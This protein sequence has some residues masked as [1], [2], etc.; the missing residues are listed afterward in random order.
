MKRI[1]ISATAAATLLGACTFSKSKS[2]DSDLRFE[3]VWAK[4][5]WI[6]Q[7]A[8]ATLGADAVLDQSTM[9]DLLQKEPEEIVDGFVSDPRFGNAVLNFN[10]YFLGRS[11][12]DLFESTNASSSGYSNAVKSMP[13]AILSARNVMENKDYFDLFATEGNFVSIKNLPEGDLPS[14]VMNFFAEIDEKYNAAKAL[15]PESNAEDAC[16]N[17]MYLDNAYQMSKYI[18]PAVGKI[19]QGWFASYF[20]YNAC[21]TMTVEQIVSRMELIKKGTDALKL[22]MENA[23][24]G[25]STEKTPTDVQFVEIKVEGLPALGDNMMGQDSFWNRLPNSST[26]FNRKRAAYVLRTFMCDDLTPLDLDS[27]TSMTGSG[28]KHATDPKCQACHYKLDPMAGLFRNYGRQGTSFKGQDTFTFDDFKTISGEQLKTY[29]GSWEENGTPKV[30][31]YVA[32]NTPDENWKGDDL[33]DLIAFMRQS[34]QVK[35]CMVRRL[36]EYVLGEEQVYDG[37]WLEEKSEKFVAGP[38][39]GSEFKNLYKTLLLSNTFREKN[40][41]HGVCYDFSTNDQDNAANRPPCAAAH[42]LKTKCETCHNKNN[43]A[44]GLELDSWTSLEGKMGFVH[45]SIDFPGTVVP[46]KETFELMQ[47]LLSKAVERNGR[48]IPVMPAGGS[49]SDSE[50]QTLFH[51]INQQLSE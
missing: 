5:G 2:G 50:K 17:F 32:P 28:N 24:R 40:P 14:G 42:I 44:G 25:T 18:G 38:N 23:P 27:L 19:E 30:G 1:V 29:M 3:S 37:G 49:L 43:A 45:N 21:D 20:T 22:A 31:F 41:E 11:V 36:A 10:L 33:V 12:N 46:R 35:Q 48:E 51:W 9:N 47:T 34:E 26:N 39:S 4:A 7:A 16:Y 8:R 15:T 6:Q 13:H